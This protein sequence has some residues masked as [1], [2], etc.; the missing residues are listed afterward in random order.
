MWANSE[1]VE[2]FEPRQHVLLQCLPKGSSY[3]ADAIRHR[4]GI[5]VLIGCD[6]I[7]ELS[8]RD[9]KDNWSFA[10]T[11]PPKRV[12]D[13]TQRLAHELDSAIDEAGECVSTHAE[14]A[15]AFLFLAVRHARGDMERA[16]QGCRIS[17]D[18]QHSCEQVE[19]LS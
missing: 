5:P 15:A 6:A 13:L 18:G 7:M 2:G 19:Y 1:T 11:L 17:W 9:V 8:A 4:G 3:L 10:K 12:T 14:E 16:L